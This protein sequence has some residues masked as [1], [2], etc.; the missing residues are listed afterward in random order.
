VLRA[1][2]EAIQSA[3]ETIVVVSP[4]NLKSQWVSVEIGMAEVL[5]K[6]IT[7]L[8]NHVDHSDSAPL[9]GRKAYEL[10][11][12]E[13][14]LVELRQRV[15]G[16][17]KM[18]YIVFI[19]HSFRDRDLAARVAD[20]VRS[21]GAQVVDWQLETEDE[22]APHITERLRQSD[23]VIVLITR[24]SA[25]N[26]WLHWEIGQAV[27]LDKPITPVMDGIDPSDLP[28][29]LNNLRAVSANNIEQLRAGLTERM[30]SNATR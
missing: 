3:D 24:H 7:P 4:Q 11:D 16:N 8:L 27:G 21:N 22:I 9:A 2:R 23:E 28:P 12:V 25:R 15:A 19:S 20:L 29:P 14:L 17:K 26:P 5:G 10:N 18:A 6:R 1:I 13:K 30:S